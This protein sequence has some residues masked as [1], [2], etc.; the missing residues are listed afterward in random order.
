MVA[1][2]FF[3][4]AGCVQS[5]SK[6]AVERRG[7]R[8]DAAHFKWHAFYS[9]CGQTLGCTVLYANRVQRRDDDKVMT[10]RLRE[11]VLTRT[12]SVEIG[13]RNFP[14]PAVVTWTSKD[15]TNHREV[16]DIRQIFRDE[17]VMHRV[18]SSDV[19]GV[20]ESPVIL[21]IVDDRT[22]RIYMKVRVRLKYEEVVGN[23]YSKYRDEL[24]LAFQ[25]TY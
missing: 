11:D 6:P 21:L 13:I 15:G 14:D 5:V 22:I 17:V 25:K 24:T 7:V 3:M 19:D 10:G 8:F 23:P 4:M 16:V 12:P 9:E 20:T 18:P 1:A 2:L